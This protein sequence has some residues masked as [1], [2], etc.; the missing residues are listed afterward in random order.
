MFL[1]FI[2]PPV[3]GICGK[4]NKKRLCT[5]CKNRL[6]K[7]K[8]NKIIDFK[9]DSTKHFDYQIKPFLY[10]D[11]IR[12]KILDYK[13]N[14]HAY[15]YE[16]FEKMIL[17]NKKIYGFLKNYDI[18]LYVPM[19]RLSKFKRGYNQTELIARK[20]AKTLGIEFVKNNLVKTKNTKKQSTLT[21]L[22]RKNNI[23]N[24]FKI[25]DSKAIYNKNVILFDDIYTT[26]STVNE[27][28]RIIKIA[29]AKSIAVLTIA[30]D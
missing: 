14:E 19:Y 16:T 23:K 24:A 27:C 29:G 8:I 13:F 28:S 6:K 21:K 3:C 26:G 15:L 2:Y 22:E 9:S 20:I 12:T 25:T 7:Y 4:I 1:N 11:I 5:K 30:V 17:N 18:I 10:K